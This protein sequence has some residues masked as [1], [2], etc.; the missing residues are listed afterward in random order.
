MRLNN[1]EGALGIIN[2]VSQ[3]RVRCAD[4]AGS[5]LP[6][7]PR[8]SKV[9]ASLQGP[10]GPGCPRVPALRDTDLGIKWQVYGPIIV[11]SENCF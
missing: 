5:G 3:S 10:Q 11:V 2:R 9:G 7:F 6:Q 8:F 4:G 1:L